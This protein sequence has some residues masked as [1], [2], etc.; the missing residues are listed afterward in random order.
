M[1]NPRGKYIQDHLSKDNLLA[2]VSI[3]QRVRTFRY[4]SAVLLFLATASGKP[5]ATRGKGLLRLRLISG[6][7]TKNR[8]AAVPSHLAL[9]CDQAQAQDR[10]VTYCI[11]MGKGLGVRG[12][13]WDY[14]QCLLAKECR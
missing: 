2:Y 12:N 7:G 5:P 13:K 4:I 10:H 6:K 3:I 9:R 1:C 8:V 11:G 14:F